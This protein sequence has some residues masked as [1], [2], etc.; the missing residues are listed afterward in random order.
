MVTDRV[1]HR[2]ARY[3]QAALCG[4]AVVVGL[5][6]LWFGS[7][8]FLL[9]FAGVL[10]AIGLRSG[11][12][13][14][15]RVTGLSPGYALALTVL[16]LAA[17]LGVF[18]YVAGQRVAEEFDQLREDL[19]QAWAHAQGQLN[20]F[21]WG[22]DL[23]SDVPSAGQL[24]TGGNHMGGVFSAFSTALSALGSVVVTGFLALYFAASPQMYRRGFL[25]LI[26]DHRRKETGAVLDRTGEQLRRWL[27]GKLALMCFVGIATAVGLWLLHVPLVLPLAVL[28]ALLDFIPNVGP[29]LS[30]IPAVLLATEQGFTTALWVA[31]VYL[32]VQVLESYILQPLVQQQNVSLP[33]ALT[34]LGQIL[35]GT[36]F[37]LLGLVLATPLTVVV[38]TVTQSVLEAQDVAEA[39]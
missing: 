17:A 36:F 25:R 24:L 15:G 13:W 21:A 31:L 11:A 35:F 26:P 3:T 5:L 28:A 10:F 30:A 14:V 8:A 38:L 19:P 27:L 29:I 39:G 6:V 7:Q 4:A 33:P 20:R 16:V 37:G 2:A 22:R 9:A 12:G 1:E 23:L 18:V 34:L 32:A